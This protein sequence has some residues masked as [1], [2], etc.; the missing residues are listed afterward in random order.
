MVGLAAGPTLPDLVVQLPFFDL[1]LDL[2]PP[3]PSLRHVLV[4]AE[5]FQ[6]P[7]P[8]RPGQ[9]ASDDPP[10]HLVLGPIV[11]PGYPTAPEPSLDVG[12]RHAVL[13]PS[14]PARP[15]AAVVLWLD[16]GRA[17]GQSSGG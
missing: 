11:L 8:T 4:Q 2:D 17:G 14:E 3:T 1:S 13:H 16:S 7:V 6:P 9:P 15:G 12:P 5:E 10:A